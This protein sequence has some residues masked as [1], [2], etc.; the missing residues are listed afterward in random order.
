M[1]DT[2]LDELNVAKTAIDEL[3]LVL[4]IEKIEM[5]SN[6]MDK[7]CIDNRLHKCN[8]DSLYSNLMSFRMTINNI[9]KDNVVKIKYTNG[10][11]NTINL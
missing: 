11:S 5:N 1:K 7:F 9:L 6:T 10:L 3:K 4:D 2:F 8:E